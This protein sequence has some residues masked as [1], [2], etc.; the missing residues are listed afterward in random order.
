VCGLWHCERSHVD[1]PRLIEGNVALQARANA[2]CCCGAA[3]GR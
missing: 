2:A 1:V 3:R